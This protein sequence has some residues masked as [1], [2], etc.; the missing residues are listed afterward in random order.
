MKAP[1]ML[2][3]TRGPAFEA[4]SGVHGYLLDRVISNGV[5]CEAHEKLLVADLLYDEI[6]ESVLHNKPPFAATGK[7]LGFKRSEHN[8]QHV[9]NQ[10]KQRLAFGANA[11]NANC[12]K[13]GC[14]A[15]R[16]KQIDDIMEEACKL[17][18]EAANH[19]D[20]LEEFLA[21]AKPKVQA[22]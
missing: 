22:T 16:F 14:L 5:M 4:L 18:P 21:W 9:V 2:A 3:E 7:M 11:V 20:E 8:L 6:K 15:W 13:P 10:V 1:E 12:D 19:F 17:P